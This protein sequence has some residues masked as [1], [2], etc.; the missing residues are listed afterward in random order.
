MCGEQK[1]AYKILV[2]E[3]KG[4][5]LLGDLV[6][7]GMTIFKICLHSVKVCIGLGGARSKI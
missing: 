4:R 7:G 5:D 2:D 3:Q 6:V 1:N